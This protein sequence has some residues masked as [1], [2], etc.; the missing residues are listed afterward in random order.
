VLISLSTFFSPPPLFNFK[1]EIFVIGKCFIFGR[2][3]CCF[4]SILFGNY[5]FA[6]WQKKR[7]FDWILKNN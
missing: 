3:A 5:F 6:D 2:Q 1:K 4:S 7:T